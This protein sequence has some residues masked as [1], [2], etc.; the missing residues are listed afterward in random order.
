MSDKS[1][2]RTTSPTLIQRVRRA[3]NKFE[4]CT[5]SPTLAEHLRRLHDDFD[6][7]NHSSAV[8]NAYTSCVEPVGFRM[9]VR[10]R[11]CYLEP[12]GATYP[13]GRATGLPANFMLPS[14]SL[15][16]TFSP[17]R[18]DRPGVVRTTRH[19]EPSLRV[20]SIA[21][22]SKRRSGSTTSGYVPDAN[23]TGGAVCRFVP[24]R[25]ERE[26]APRRLAR[27][28]RLNHHGRDPDDTPPL[29][30]DPSSSLDS[31]VDLDEPKRRQD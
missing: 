30:N 10:A 27:P 31:P 2:S 8:L 1:N 4:V 7:S 28:R 23:C 15:P 13:G 20:P 12:G 16:G 6:E 9:L 26:S 11:G 14:A 19:V 24:N 5:T 22:A 18:Q 17:R 25:L 3:H 29:V 21:R